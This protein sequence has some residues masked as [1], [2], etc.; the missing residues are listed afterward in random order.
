MEMAK[1]TRGKNYVSTL[2]RDVWQRSL[3]LTC[4]KPTL[5]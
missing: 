4:S 1:A 2:L 3:E 5:R